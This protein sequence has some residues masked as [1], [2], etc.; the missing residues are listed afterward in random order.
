VPKTGQC[1][2]DVGLGATDGHAEQGLLREGTGVGRAENG[3][4]LADAHDV[5]H[6]FLQDGGVGRGR[7][8]HGDL[9]ADGAEAQT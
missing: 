8:G 2:G 1:A 4:G 3:Q 7:Q 6:R 9:L 5:G